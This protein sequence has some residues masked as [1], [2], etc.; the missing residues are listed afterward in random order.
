[1]DGIFVN[2]TNED[3]LYLGQN[4]VPNTDG[5]DTFRSDRISLLNWDVTCGDDCLAIKGNSSNLVVRNITCRGGN[6]IAFGSLG[7]YVG[8]NDYVTNV[9]MEDLRVYF[10]SWDGSVNGAPPT[11]GGGAGGDHTGLVD[12]VVARN[13]QL[14]RVTNVVHLYQTNGGHSNWTG[15]AVSNTIV[16]L[17]CSPAVGCGAITLAILTFRH[18]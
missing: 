16:D 10:K 18:R 5:I 8:L 13:V 9:D 3:P 1:M 12:N 15:T 11:G 17:Q 4:I 14:D 6:G 7:Q 2:A